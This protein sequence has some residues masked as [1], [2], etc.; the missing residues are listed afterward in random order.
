[1]GFFN[2]SDV[3]DTVFFWDGNRIARSFFQKI[4]RFF[5]RHIYFLFCHKSHFRLKFENVLALVMSQHV[6]KLK[7]CA[8]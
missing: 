8:S 4:S 3:I 5:P 2:Q 7:S 1:M 6:I